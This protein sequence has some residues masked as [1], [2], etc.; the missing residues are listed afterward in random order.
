M[1]TED[2][3][4]ILE[5]RDLVPESVTSQLRKKAAQGD[6]RITPKAILKYLVKKELVTRRQAKQLLETTLTVTPL[7]E[8]SIL[9]M[10]PMPKA[11]SEPRPPKVEEPPPAPPI[12]PAAPPL[13]EGRVSL[14]PEAPEQEDLSSLVSESFSGTETAESFS[15]DVSDSVE[16]R[17]KK[18]KADRKKKSEWDSPLVVFGGGGLALLLII[19][20][21]VFILI[22]REDAEAVLREASNYFEDGAYTQAI[23]QYE[24]FVEKFPNHPQFSAAKVKLGMARIWKETD[25]ASD[26]VKALDT[27]KQVLK[28]IEDEPEFSSIHQ[29]LAP[30]LEAIALGLANQAEK[31]REPERIDEL[32]ELANKS[33]ALCTNTKYSLIKYR[34]PVVLEEVR[35]TIDRVKKAREQNVK[36]TESLG[37]IDGALGN[38]DTAQAFAIYRK[39]LNEN[40]GLL[41]N[42]QLSAKVQEIS[43]SEGTVVQFLPETFDPLQTERDTNVLATLTLAEP[44]SNNSTTTKGHVAVRLN[45][46]AFGLRASDG[47][48]LWRR[49]VGISPTLFPQRLPNGDFLIVDS[50]HHDLL[51]V[52][53]DTGKLI[54]RQEL[55]EP[56]LQPVI[57]AEQIYV[58]DKSGKLH[59]IE[60]ASGVHKG[61]VLLPQKLR[62]PPLVNEKSGRIYVVGDHSSLYSL[63]TDDYSCRGV[64]FLGHEAGSIATAPAMALGRILVAE[65]VGSSTSQIKVL[66]TDKEGVVDDLLTSRRLQGLV[67]TP[68]LTEKRRLVVVTSKGFIGVYE[69]GPGEGDASMT[70]IATRD[71]EKSS[72]IARYATFE[73][74]FVWV[75]GKKL[76]KLA[77]LPTGNRLPVQD[78]DRDYL[79]DVFDH[80][81]QTVGD[82][83]VHVR[84]PRNA[85]GAKVAAMEMSTGRAKWET[86][87]A[88]P[89]AGD[90]TVDSS[91]SEIYAM[92]SSAAGFAVDREAFRRGVYSEAKVLRTS[93]RRDLPTFT[94]SIPLGKEGRAA[95]SLGSPTIVCFHPKSNSR[96]LVRIEL[97]S[98]LSCRPIA[99][100]SKLVAPTEVGQVY[101][102]DHSTGQQLG[103][104]FQ[105]ALAPKETHHWLPPTVY[106]PDEQSQL[107]LSNGQKQLFRLAYV[108]EPQPHLNAEIEADVGASALSTQLSALG[109]R[110][111][112]GTTDGQVA[113]Y[114]MPDLE[115]LPLVD[116]GGQ[117]VSGPV[118]ASD[119]WLMAIDSDEL[120]ALGPEGNVLWRQSHGHGP[121][122]GEPLILGSDI[123]VLFQQGILSRIRVSDGSEQGH[124]ELQQPVLS[125]PVA[126]N[127]KII[128]ATPDGT[129]LVLNRP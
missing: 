27:A 95:F 68:M 114:Q 15:E 126:F 108:S 34:D 125:G 113:L 67:T 11:P 77:V 22:G 48:V 99:W 24:S 122:A 76:T 129:L 55:Q 26:F 35:Q 1:T 105:P 80:T 47:S 45:G 16:R 42:E 109:E 128:V 19:G 43:Q 63:S 40:P 29:D 39:L 12:E 57:T 102:F 58:G 32:V 25:G 112:A 65:N 17:A 98:P 115:P 71:A 117:V 64:Y 120:V 53:G 88:V 123:F 119:F 74:G 83:V 14:A 28:E 21:T 91:T 50:T 111:C 97:P 106:R 33:R 116:L 52:S 13:P 20:V 124:I 104:P 51:R 118:A 100:G 6:T 70:Q 9:G 93:Q 18:R 86:R 49:F 46:S 121:L 103:S 107:I 110:I 101:L 31:A 78:T 94:Q 36:L 89:L 82:L 90:L 92:T 79:G 5:Q 38:R 30:R 59:V 66:S 3:I 85:S 84:R 23:S 73:R 96:P 87:L 69:A 60:L 81:L 4:D 2:F 62:V 37:A 44:S 127:K 61:H 41:N 56:L 75:A 10:V 7:A 72:A 54:W 8:S